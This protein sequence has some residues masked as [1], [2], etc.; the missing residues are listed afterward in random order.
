LSCQVHVRGSFGQSFIGTTPTG[1]CYCHLLISKLMLGRAKRTADIRAANPGLTVLLKRSPNAGRASVPLQ[2]DCRVAKSHD[3]TSVWLSR[4]LAKLFEWPECVPDRPRNVPSAEPW[5]RA[6][7]RAAV[8]DAAEVF[9]SSAFSGSTN[10]Q[11]DHTSGLAMPAG[12][13]M[14]NNSAG[15]GF[16]RILALIFR[17][18][19]V[20]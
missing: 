5:R 8:S 13:D 4:R 15:I 3:D 18:S 16:C 11:S 7:A 14:Q 10:L 17:P 2:K 19:K 12:C 20:A 1:Q 9:R 6:V